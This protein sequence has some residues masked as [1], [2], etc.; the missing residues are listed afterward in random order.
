MNNKVSNINKVS[1]QRKLYISNNPGL[2]MMA[3]NISHL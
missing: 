2:K 3:I 1:D